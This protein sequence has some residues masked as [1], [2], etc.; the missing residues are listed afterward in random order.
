MTDDAIVLLSG[1]G[2]K[3]WYID[4]REQRNMESIAEAN[5]TSAFDR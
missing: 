5:E 2:K 1:A 3:A 4:E